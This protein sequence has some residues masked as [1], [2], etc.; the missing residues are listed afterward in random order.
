MT[1]F[2]PFEKGVTVLSSSFALTAITAS[3]PASANTRVLS[4][5]YAPTAAYPGPQGNPGTSYSTADCPAGYIECPN[6]L[7]FVTP[8]YAKVCLQIGDGCPPGQFV[9]C[10]STIPSP[11]TTTTTS[12]TTTTTTGAPTTTTT[13][14]TEAPTTTTTTEAPTTTTTTEAPTT[15]TTTAACIGEGDVCL[16]ASPNCCSGYTCDPTDPTYGICIWDGTP[17][18]STT[19]TTTTVAPTTTTTTTTAAPV[20]TSVAISDT[21]TSNGTAPSPCG[22]YP[23]ARNTTSILLKDQY[24]NNITNGGTAVDVVIRY[25]KSGV[26]NNDITLTIPA[27]QLAGDPI[28]RE[29]AQSTYVD[30]SGCVNETED[31]TCV[32]SVSG[33]LSYTGLAGC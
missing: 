5:S 7:S 8:T 9:T 3:N 21:N 4:A 31:I 20:A 26:G 33:G 25:N 24:G 17:T 19:T 18:T 15:T 27:Y 1:Y 32:V 11:C 28:T 2:Y 10:P 6:L 16:N 23:E 12:T 13:T 14:T 22:S 29:Y 30:E